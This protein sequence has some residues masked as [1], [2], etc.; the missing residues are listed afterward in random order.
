MMKNEAIALYLLDEGL[1]EDQSRDSLF[2]VEYM[3]ADGSISA[4]QWTMRTLWDEI[5]DDV[6]RILSLEQL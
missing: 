2:W 6:V 1:T 4:D 5:R 3:E